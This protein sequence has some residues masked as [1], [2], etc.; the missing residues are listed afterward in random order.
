MSAKIKMGARCNTDVE[1][2]GKNPSRF[3][4]S[5]Q[6]KWECFDT[7]GKPVWQDENHNVCTIQG[8][9]HL[10]NVAFHGATQISPWYVAVFED[11]YTSLEADTYAVPGYTESTAYDEATRPEYVEA[12]A[13]G[14]VMTNSANKAS[15][16][17]NAAKTI[18][19]SGLVGG[20]SAPSTK[21][22]TAGSGTLYAAA[23][24]ST[25]GKPVDVGYVLKVTWTLTGSDVS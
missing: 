11:N 19:G 12:S 21:G 14:K 9:N 6:V 22:D 2:A 24:F 1:M 16:T 5:S 20:G 13:S 7:Q 23:K 17:F 15:F 25:G 4:V 3:L 8:L 18:Y 10:L